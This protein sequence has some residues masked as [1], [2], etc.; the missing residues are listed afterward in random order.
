MPEVK[1]PSV[2]KDAP[3]LESMPLAKLKAFAESDDQVEDYVL[4]LP[5]VKEC[6]QYRDNLRADVYQ[7]AQENLNYK[8]TIEQRRVELVELSKQLTQLKSEYESL[9]REQNSLS[10]KFSPDELKRLTE[11]GIQKIDEESLETVDKFLD[12]EES[13]DAFVKQFVQQRRLYHV[14][15]AKLERLRVTTE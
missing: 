11:D 7:M 4:E 15:A 2:P 5:E 9:Q 12:G 8:Q 13:V 10:H 3:A 6:T 1:L 14:R